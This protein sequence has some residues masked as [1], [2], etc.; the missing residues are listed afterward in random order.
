MKK[1]AFDL[2]ISSN[3]LRL[4]KARRE[5]LDAKQKAAADLL[6]I[7]LAERFRRPA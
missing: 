4:K 1:L 3:R 7:V 5:G 6:D 2:I